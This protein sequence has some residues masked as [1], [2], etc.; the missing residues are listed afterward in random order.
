MKKKWGK[1]PENN[2]RD[3]C[4]FELYLVKKSLGYI[5]L[6]SS[7][8]FCISLTYILQSRAEKSVNYFSPM[9]N[10]EVL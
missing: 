10:F 2:K 5:F 8:M 7:V 6:S 9:I 1:K 3:N 4:Q